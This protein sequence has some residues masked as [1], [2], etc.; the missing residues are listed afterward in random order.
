MPRVVHTLYRVLRP[1]RLLL[2]VKGPLKMALSG[3]GV[4]DSWR[5]A[6]VALAAL[7]TVKTGGE[8]LMTFKKICREWDVRAEGSKV[9]Q[10]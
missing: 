2:V 8:V 7:E 10:C 5:V 3:S 4:V 9:I 6:G 1:A